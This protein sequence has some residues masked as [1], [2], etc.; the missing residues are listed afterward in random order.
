LASTTSATKAKPS[1][2]P[3]DDEALVE[4]RPPP[5]AGFSGTAKFYAVAQ[6]PLIAELLKR[7]YTTVER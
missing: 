6:A 4:L 7:G 1:P 5:G 2:P 3:S